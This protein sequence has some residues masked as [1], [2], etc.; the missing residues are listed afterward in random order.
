MSRD[1]FRINVWQSAS[2]HRYVYAGNNPVDFN[3]PTG[4][5]FT[6]ILSKILGLSK[7][8][9]EDRMVESRTFLPIDVRV[10]PIKVTGSGW[11]RAAIESQL[12]FAKEVFARQAGLRLYPEDVELTSAIPPAFGFYGAQRYIEMFDG[13]ED[14]LIRIP[15]IYSERLRPDTGSHLETFLGG[16]GLSPPGEDAQGAVVFRFKKWPDDPAHP[17]GLSVTG[18]ELAHALSVRGH[19]PDVRN[20]LCGNTGGDPTVDI[21]PCRGRT[22]T[23]LTD[24]QVRRMR[25]GAR[26]FFLK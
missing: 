15:V 13:L 26:G 16:L 19:F 9:D 23:R 3:D 22:G 2:I 10:R 6:K 18:H 20:L 25:L 1:P 12:N 4:L 5:Y 7:L 17:I 24:G 11:T 14:S 21:S 8:E